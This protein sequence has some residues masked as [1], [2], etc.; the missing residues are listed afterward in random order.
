MS[1]YYKN[2]IQSNWSKNILQCINK[3]D[4]KLNDVAMLS[5]N[6]CVHPQ[7]IVVEELMQVGL[8]IAGSHFK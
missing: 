3:V 4:F 1:L 5:S 6:D 8:N 7:L 2:D